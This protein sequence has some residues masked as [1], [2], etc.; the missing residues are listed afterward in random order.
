MATEL[1]HD[2]LLGC[3]RDDN[4]ARQYCNTNQ[5]INVA[6]TRKAVS[7]HQ[8][9]EADQHHYRDKKTFLVT[10]IYRSC[11]ETVLQHSGLR[12]EQNMVAK[13]ETLSR[14]SYHTEGRKKVATRICCRNSNKNE[15]KII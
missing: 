5:N 4:N 15:H 9:E 11:A 10:P 1:C 14:Q 7:Q 12:N 6:A 3:D 2:R 8:N 13:K